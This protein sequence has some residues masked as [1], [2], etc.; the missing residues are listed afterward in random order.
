[1]NTL[2]RQMRPVDLA[3]Q[4]RMERQ[5]HKGAFLVFEGSN[6]IRRFRKFFNEEI[7]SFVN[8]FGRE[9]VEGAIEIED[10]NGRI[11][12][13]GFVDADFDAIIGNAV[14]SDNVIASE[15]HDFDVD[16]CATSA[17]D[18]YLV[19][20]A[21]AN[22]VIDC[23]GATAC[24]E[25][26]MHAL[27]PLSAARYASVRYGMQYSF[28]GV[29]HRAFFDGYVVDI[30]SL[31]DH[32]SQGRFSDPASRQA[33]RERIDQFVESDI[34]LWQVTNG[35]DLMAAIGIAL[36]QRLGN[37]AYPQ[38]WR[39]EVEKHLR[40]TFDPNDFDEAGLRAKVIAWVGSENGRTSPLR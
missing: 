25:S 33:L 28:E 6:D 1:M 3:A 24:L 15:K 22:K 18:R 17:L 13:L 29:D 9:N 32:L 30:D 14:A 23:G 34:D 39:S 37:R 36:R 27:K 31:V 5:L 8:A 7:C 19:E 38:T 16:V 12:L 4:I 11:D 10:N 35:H 40:L 21:D 26:L 2:A 20:V